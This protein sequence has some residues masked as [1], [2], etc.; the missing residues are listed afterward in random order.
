M[1]PS[2]TTLPNAHPSLHAL[3]L[4]GITT[5]DRRRGGRCPAHLPARCDLRLDLVQLR[6]RA[7]LLMR[8]FSAPYRAVGMPMLVRI[9]SEGPGGRER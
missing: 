8:A 1:L 7:I 5:G 2:A 6:C 4:V 9:E 3:S